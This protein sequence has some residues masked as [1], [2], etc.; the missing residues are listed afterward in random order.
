MA[1]NHR[2]PRSIITPDALEVSSE[3][4]GRPLAS[5]RRRAAALGVDG[6][7]IV[8][9]T[10]LTNSF[11]LIV[12]VVAAALFVRAG[13][14]RTP[15][16]GSV[17]GRAMRFS[18]GCLG[19]VIAI[20]TTGAWALFGPNLGRDGS[21]TG[22]AVV[23]A[24]RQ[25]TGGAVTFALIEELQ[26]AD[27]LDEA[28]ELAED[29]IELG[30]E[31]GVDDDDVRGGLSAIVAESD[32]EWADAFEAMLDELFE[33]GGVAAPSEADAAEMDALSDEDALRAL[34]TLSGEDLS[35]EDVQRR[36]ALR[37]RLVPAVAGDS[38]ARL[39]DR[40]ETLEDRRAAAQT[41]LSEAEA[42][43][44]AAEG[45]GIRSR[46]LDLL[47]ELG[48]G[49]GWAAIYLTV[50]L[51]WWNGQTVGKRL[52]GIRVVRL[53][54][55]PITW[56]VAFERAGGYAAGLFTGL[57]GFAQVWWDSNRQAIHDRIVGTVVVREGAE[58]VLNWEEAL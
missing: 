58:K 46:I 18:V 38:L 25:I 57:L 4:F 20:I 6:L 26:D 8:F 34:A 45:R 44:Q 10:A 17:F 19:V 55:E 39:E 12:G 37:A 53:D 31:L 1:S 27:S 28:R 15:V 24:A 21:S 7:V 23:Q 56:W 52:F 41:Q 13:F 40:I 22:A 48:F 14:K 42:E 50:I 33:D 5:P 35:D 54:G 43:L 16:R 2:D 36:D 11:A 47:D 32:E 29:A 3:L 30:R 51:S 49:F 9:I